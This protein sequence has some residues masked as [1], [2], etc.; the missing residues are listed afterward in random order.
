AAGEATPATRDHGV[1]TAKDAGLGD[2]AAPAEASLASASEISTG[3]GSQSGSDEAIIAASDRGVLTSAEDAGL[4]PPPAE[5][6]LAS[7][8]EISTGLG[9]QSG[10]DEAILAA[11][12]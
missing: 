2:T 3:L 7:A 9:G 6:S 8:S 5:A 1:L 11:S 10:S 12:D 4:T